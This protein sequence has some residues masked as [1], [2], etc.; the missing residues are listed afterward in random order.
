VTG[1]CLRDRGC[2]AH[3]ERNHHEK[4]KKIFGEIIFGSSAPIGS[5]LRE[6]IAAG[7]SKAIRNGRRRIKRTSRLSSITKRRRAIDR[8]FR[9]AREVAAR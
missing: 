4:I 1:G 2:S 9:V 8:H 7:S 6:S 5:C 3:V